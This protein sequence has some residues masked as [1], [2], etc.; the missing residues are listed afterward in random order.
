MSIL[1]R[2]TPAPAQP[3]PR[4]QTLADLETRHNAALV[5]IHHGLKH[6][7]SVTALRDALL[8]ARLALQPLTKGG[9]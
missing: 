3:D 5:A 2:R 9:T 8:D 4:E 6:A 1:G 7:S